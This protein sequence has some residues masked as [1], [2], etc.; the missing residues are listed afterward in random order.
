MHKLEKLILE[1]YGQL[2]NEM[3]G[4]RLFD[5]FNNKGY[6][7][8]ERSSD[9]GVPGFEGYMVSKGEGR[10]PQAVIF[11][12]NKDIDEFTISRMS[13]YRID[14]EEAMKAG[15]REKSSSAVVGIDGYMTDGNYTP[16][17][18]SVEDLKDI[19][20]HV[21]S[22]IEREAEAQRDFYAR[23]GPVSGTI[24][25]ALSYAFS[26]YNFTIKDDA[27]QAEVEAKI[28]K[29]L[30]KVQ[31]KPLEI[32]EKDLQAIIKNAENYFAKE[33]RKEEKANRKPRK[34]KSTEF[35]QFAADYYTEEYYPNKYAKDY[36]DKRG[37]MK[38]IQKGYSP[39]QAERFR[40][41]DVIPFLIDYD[42]KG[43]DSTKSIGLYNM[44]DDFYTMDAE[45]FDKKYE[46][47]KRRE[48]KRRADRLKDPDFPT[49][50]LQ[51]R[52]GGPLKLQKD[53]YTM[54]VWEF[55][56]I[57]GKG[58]EIE[59]EDFN[60]EDYSRLGFLNEKDDESFDLEKEFEENP[61]LTR[62]KDLPADMQKKF[63]KEIKVFGKN[64]PGDPNRDYVD[65]DYETYYFTTSYNKETGSVGH[66][67]VKL[68]SYAKLYNSFVKIIKDIKTLMGVDAVKN[69]SA[70]K[71]IFE[72][73]KTLFR[74]LQRYLRTNHP[75]Q[76]DLMKMRR[77]AEGIKKAK[78]LLETNFNLKEGEEKTYKGKDYKVTLEKGRK[79]TLK[80]VHQA[81]YKENPSL[82]KDR[83]HQVAK[84]IH[85]S[86]SEGEGDDHHYI[87]VPRREFKKA[88]AIIAQNIDS[89]FVKMDYVDNDGAGN[90][91]IY[92][93]FRDGDIASGE[94]DSFMFDVV[95]DLEAYGIMI[96]DHSAELEE[97]VNEKMDINDPI[98]I[99]LRQAK[100]RADDMK[101]LD[102]YKKSPE[103][104]AAAR[105]QASAERKEIKAREIVRKLKI[106]RAQV[107]SDMENDPDV[108]PTGGPVADMYG[109]QLNK[110]DNAIEKAA[111]VYN[112]NMSYDQAVGKINEFIGGNTEK[113]ISALFDKL[114]P[115]SGNAA[116]VEGEIIRAIN[117]I[118]YRWGNDGDL[119]WSGYG[120]ETAGP[121]MEFLTDAS[122]IP[123]EIRT[124]FRAWEND[125][126]GKD[127]DKKE[128]ENLA[129]IA[130]QYVEM[131]VREGD[132]SP[133]NDDIFNYGQKYIDY[134]RDMEDEE[135]EYDDYYDDEDEDDE[136]YYNED[137]GQEI[138][139]ANMDGYKKGNLKENLL[140]KVNEQEPEEKPD[141]TAPKET[142]LEDATDQM[143]SKFP[144]LK[145][146][147]IK[148]QTED[149]K[150]FVNTIDWISPRPTTFRINLKNGQDYILKWTGKTFQAQIMGKRYFIDK[151]NDYQQALDKLN[152]LYKE[153]PM[154]GAGE[155]EP[156][157]PIDTSGDGGGGGD[158]PGV[159]APAG[160]DE[161]PADD[162]GGEEGGA[163]L[164]GEPVDFEEP[165]E[166]PE[167]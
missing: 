13:G 150:E 138:S 67:I 155:E 119:F 10:S 66:R 132:L 106:K 86:L 149:F 90:V 77:M 156:A 75:K 115:D 94:A 32:P 69:D 142:V 120:A 26:E 88:E 148:L 60:I 127:Y 43:K 54:R 29:E 89:N 2:L 18:I 30:K 48:I 1:A 65:A 123:L 103:G 147:I 139:K 56:K 58:G 163:D 5:Y 49:E 85:R 72:N 25:E 130:L 122:D 157:D 21:M 105:A 40:R 61:R 137:R 164:T 100:M 81:T 112:K 144:T 27:Y 128:L 109:D 107:M 4:G 28:K 93:M 53:F 3:D 161:A 59:D 12:Y 33:A 22:G 74:Q 162:A 41:S 8:S 98:M 145:A 121:A 108:E 16:V 20:D 78:T 165:A 37:D 160:G 111:S 68:P 73:I 42:V 31:S 79:Y 55:D 44:P 7:I 19:V 34:I 23:R 152:I 24:D 113:R 91:I 99:K 80:G 62:F 15:M 126:F 97:N 50:K 47:Y 51:D 118:I 14:Q 124:K 158:F 134:V 102:A 6:K 70:A 57:Y 84:Q 76:Y 125:N 153:G 39:D 110:I 135:D 104:R 140:D 92:F 117:R 17:D 95:M 129:Q 64:A 131:K 143:L 116:T 45:E 151:I 136:D 141:L 159:D 154:S 167:A 96:P 11:Q 83:A 87:K 46:I 71:E 82:S 35:A 63:S 52:P 133:N 36:P 101:K 146:A 114:V 9:G 38:A 166:E